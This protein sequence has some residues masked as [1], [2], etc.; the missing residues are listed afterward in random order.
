MSA[1]GGVVGA[2]L[3]FAATVVLLLQG[4]APG[5]PVGS[6]LGVLGDYL[7]GYDVSWTGASVGALY[8][9][10]AGAIIGFVLAM[11]WNITHLLI[12]RVLMLQRL[13]SRI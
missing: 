3:L 12:I 4:P 8:G 1:A 5:A 6:T 7:L 13:I 11:F 9:F 2:L 10:L